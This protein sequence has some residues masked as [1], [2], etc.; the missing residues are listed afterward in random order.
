MDCLRSFIVRIDQVQTFTG[1]NVKTWT[2]GLQEYWAVDAGA[3]STFVVEGFKNIDVYGV[4]LIGHVQTSTTPPTSGV[5]VESWAFEIEINGQL[6]LINGNLGTGTNSWNLQTT[7]ALAKQFALSNY[8]NY[9][10]FADPIKSVQ[11]IRFFALA[12]QGIGGQT[13]GS[14]SLDYDLSFIVYYKYEGE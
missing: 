11:D 4:E 14:I 6:P 13:I 10:T 1:A 3:V 8:T 9:L 12:A 7:G 2:L 5:V